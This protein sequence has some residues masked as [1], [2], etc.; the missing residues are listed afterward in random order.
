[1]LPARHLVR[2]VAKTVRDLDLREVYAEYGESGGVAYAPELLLSLIIYGYITGIESSRKIE[3]AT[4]RDIAWMWLAGG[5]HPDHDTINSFRERFKRQIDG[6]FEQVVKKA[7]E[8][9]IVKMENVSGDGSKIHANASKSKAMSYERIMERKKMLEKEVEELTALEEEEIPAGM[10]R[11]DEIGLRNLK[12][13]R[14][15]EAEK[16]L[17]RRAE[18]RYED[19]V[20]AYK[21]RMAER[22]AEEKETGKK[23]SGPKPEEPKPTGPRGKDQYNFTDPE[24][25]IMPEGNHDGYEQSYNAQVVVDQDSLLIV[26]ELLSDKPNDKRLAI[27]LLDAI[28]SEIG[29][30]KNVAFD[31]GYWSEENVAEIGK[32]G[33]EAYIATGREPHHISWQERFLSSPE[34]PGKD[35]SAKVKMAYKLKTGEGKKIYRRRKF[36]V[37]PVFGIIKEVMGFRQFSLRGMA[38]AA[39]EW[40]LVCLAYNLKR[41]HQILW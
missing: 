27:P 4:K 22:A 35:A 13:S 12:I 1:M 41:L 7:I 17:E 34:S 33:I 30:P 11:A 6:I 14:L 29:Q 20:A 38:N 26:G 28:S 37:E 8:M 39:G 32:R 2:F 24:S 10:N 23:I 25:R 18:E 15:C 9:G 40:T 31:N 3:E 19:E 16:E 5:H 36:T 21:E